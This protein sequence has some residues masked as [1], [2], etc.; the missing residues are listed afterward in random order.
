MALKIINYRQANDNDFDLTFT[1]KT[2]S[3]RQ[4][5]EKI[6]GWDNAI[7][8]DYHKRQFNPNKTKIIIYENNQVGYISIFETDDTIFIENIHIDTAFQGKG[9]G[10]KVILDTIKIA[11]RHNKNIE[12][13]VIKINESAIRLYERLDF[14]T[15]E[16]KD[17]H[18]KMRYKPNE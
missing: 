7:Q 14:E 3:S 10:T 17:L 5:V 2:N 15:F 11:V 16:Q 12:L 6:W 4:L 8:I 18:Y 13:Q 1:I 9:I